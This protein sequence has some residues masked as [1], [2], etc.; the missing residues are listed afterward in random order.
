MFLMVCSTT[1]STLVYVIIHG[2][3]RFEYNSSKMRLLSLHAL[4]LH[5]THFVHWD[6]HSNI[7]NYI[8]GSDICTVEMLM[9]QILTIGGS[10]FEGAERDI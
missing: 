7:S 2:N 1:C 6:C 3:R 10:V 4:D 5:N 8:T 9:T